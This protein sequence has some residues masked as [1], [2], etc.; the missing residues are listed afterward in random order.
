MFIVKIN[1]VLEVRI[2]I[3]VFLQ[4]LEDSLRDDIIVFGEDNQFVKFFVRVREIII[5]YL[6]EDE[7][8]ILFIMFIIFIVGQFQE[9]NRF[10]VIEFN[11]VE[12]LLVASRVERDEFG[13][14]Y[15]VISDKVSL[16]CREMVQ[17]LEILRDEERQESFR[18]IQNIQR[19]W[20]S[21]NYI[22][23][24]LMLMRG[25]ERQVSFR[26]I[27]KKFKEI[28]SLEIREIQIGRDD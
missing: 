23:I 7:D 25:K 5:K 17:I 12:D 10:F 6:Q 21:C 15:N 13:I 18:F 19:N 9:E 16:E 8:Y 27:Y 1:F 3:D 22:E 24:V 4:R 11:R 14:K 28:E 20:K 2:N 26:F